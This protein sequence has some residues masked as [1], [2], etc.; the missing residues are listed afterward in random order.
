VYP[1]FYKVQPCEVSFPEKGKLAC[2]FKKLAKRHDKTL[3]EEWRADL[4]RASKL[5]GWEHKVRDKR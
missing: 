1:I 4:K 5:D 3:I 2:G